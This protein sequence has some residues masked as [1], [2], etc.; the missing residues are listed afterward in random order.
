[1]QVGLVQ[2]YALVSSLQRDH[3]DL[4]RGVAI[5][6]GST[7]NYQKVAE[8][9]GWSKKNRNRK[10]TRNDG[11]APNTTN[12]LLGTKGTKKIG[13][14]VGSVNVDRNPVTTFQ[15]FTAS[16][17]AGR[18]NRCWLDAMVECFHALQTPLWFHGAKGNSSHIYTK[19]MKLLSSRSTW[20]MSQNGSIRTILSLGQ[21]T[22]HAAAQAASV[23]FPTDQFA[24]ADTFFE[25]IFDARNQG[26][27]VPAPTRTLFR[28]NRLRKLVCSHDPLHWL[29]ETIATNTI[30][31]CPQDFENKYSYSETPKLLEEWASPAGIRGLSNRHCQLC[32]KTDKGRVPF[33]ER[34]QISFEPDPPPPHLYIHLELSSFLVSESK[35]SEMVNMQANCL[36]PY[37]LKLH[38][39]TYFM[40][41]RGFWAASHFWCQVVRTVGGLAGVWYHNDL[42]NAGN[43]TLISRELETI[44][45]AWPKTSW[46]MYSREPTADEAVIIEEARAKISK[47]NPQPQ[48]DIPFSQTTM[49]GTTTPESEEGESLMPLSSSLSKSLKI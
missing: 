6:Y 49:V 17:T 24:S 41:A 28:L 14:P 32:K 12:F 9:L 26:L 18:R 25:L 35:R 11:R 21:N 8:T 16:Q 46:A 38:G 42:E 45:G 37:E 29:N 39:I 30:N 15:G 23:S 2:L 1:M 47:L 4:L 31:L 33:V 44:G 13:R 22:I 7:K 43:A 40:R 3:T 19:I 10:D 36:L 34:N 48:G 27:A 20:E 5:E